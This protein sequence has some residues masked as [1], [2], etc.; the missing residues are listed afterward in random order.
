[1]QSAVI[2][3]SAHEPL[4]IDPQQRPGYRN[5][6]LK[7]YKIK[8]VTKCAHNFA[9]FKIRSQNDNSK[10]WIEI[11]ALITNQLPKKPYSGPISANITEDFTPSL[12]ADIYSDVY[13]AIR[14]YGAINTEVG[15]VVAEKSALGYLF[16][17][18]IQNLW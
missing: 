2:P 11:T 6:L 5:H 16:S 18:P 7:K 8:R 14:R 13:F 12:L 3:G 9:V 10:W 17:G 15:Q 4:S 1:M